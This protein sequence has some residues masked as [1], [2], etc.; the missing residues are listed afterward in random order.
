MLQ[1]FLQ[2]HTQMR[3]RMDYLSCLEVQEFAAVIHF[4]RGLIGTR[5]CKNIPKQCLAKAGNLVWP[6]RFY[7]LVCPKIQKTFWLMQSKLGTRE[8]WLPEQVNWRRIYSMDLWRNH[9]W[10][11]SINVL[12]LSNGGWRDPLS[13]KK[14]RNVCMHLFRHTSSRFFLASVCFCG[15]RYFRSWIILTARWWMI[16]AMASRWQGGPKRRMC[17]NRVSEN[18]STV[19]NSWRRSRRAWMQRCWVLWP[20]ASGQKL[21]AKFGRT[22]KMNLLRVG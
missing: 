10:P 20:K 9:C 19:W 7:R 11:G 6:R 5:C 17:S 21:T 14:M 16:F 13:W 4:N 12:W 22:L 1:W 2:L 3:S 15:K 8:T 18:L